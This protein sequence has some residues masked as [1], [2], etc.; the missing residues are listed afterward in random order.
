L[1]VAFSGVDGAGKSTQAGRL[2]ETLARIGVEAVA[3]WPPAQ[4]VLFGMNPTLKRKLRHA[5]ERIGS[6]HGAGRRQQDDPDDLTDVEHST[7]PQLQDPPEFPPVPRHRA[8]FAHALAWVVALSQV[9]ALRRAMRGCPRTARVLIFD[10]FTLD[11]IVSVRHR[12][13]DARPLRWQCLL[14]RLLSPRPAA[15]YLLEIDP[16]RA[17]ARKRDFP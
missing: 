10:R 9:L 8:P 3:V 7:D 13:G 6:P 15:A 11:S 17:L 12:W 5:L 1:I 4:N 14:I 16:E 2:Q